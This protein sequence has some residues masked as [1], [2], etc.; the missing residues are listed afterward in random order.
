MVDVIGGVIIETRLVVLL[1][2]AGLIGKGSS[3]VLPSCY[4]IFVEGN[5]LIGHVG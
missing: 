4:I 2:F 3:F 1:V 5:V